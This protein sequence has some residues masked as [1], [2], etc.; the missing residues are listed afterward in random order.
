MEQEQLSAIAETIINAKGLII[1]AGS[2][3][4]VDSG[5]PDFRG[6]KG[7]WDAYPHYKE[8]NIDFADVANF[9]NLLKDPATGWGFYGQRANLYRRLKPHRGY[10]ML[11][12]WCA[13]Y[14]LESFVVTT[15][16]DCQFQM[17]GFPEE[18]ILEMHGTVHHLQCTVPCCD[19]I[20]ENTEPIPV[21]EQTM[22]ALEIPK[23]PHCGELAR[24]NILMYEDHRWNYQRIGTQEQAFEKFL[25]ERQND[26]L[27]IIELGAGI[28][29][30]TLRLMSEK[31]GQQPNVRV[32]RVNPKENFITPPHFSCAGGALEVIEEID[33]E[34]RS[35]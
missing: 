2:G 35:L 16:V 9:Q 33:Q 31:F 24:P 15:N 23:C 13:R 4:S 18:S 8:Q 32:I 7:F 22:Q 28:W 21:D 20:W 5:L 27:V 19:A 12:D 29:V 25:Q 6:G 30:P 14:N 26:P 34:L 3:M 10:Q 11:L 1:S 17:A